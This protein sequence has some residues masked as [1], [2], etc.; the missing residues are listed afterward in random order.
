MQDV[1]LDNIHLFVDH[2]HF[3]FVALVNLR[4]K[5]QYQQYVSTIRA[6]PT[7]THLHPKWVLTPFDSWSHDS[8]R[9]NKRDVMV[10]HKLLSAAVPGMKALV[11]R[12]LGQKTRKF[13]SISTKMA[14]PGISPLVQML[15]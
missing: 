8:P 4:L 7:V 9:S 1:W 14:A 13:G 15:P 6:P 3:L 10:S 11:A 12:L 5:E 2:G